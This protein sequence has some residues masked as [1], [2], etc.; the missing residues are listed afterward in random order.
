VRRADVAVI[1]GASG[2]SRST[3]TECFVREECKQNVPADG[4]RREQVERARIEMPG[5]LKKFGGVEVEEGRAKRTGTL[6]F[7]I[8]V[9]HDNKTI[10]FVRDVKE[11]VERGDSRSRFRKLWRRGP[12]ER[13]G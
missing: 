12:G 9:A 7:E 1:R 4:D 13:R 10:F 2:L 5:A 6:R 3:T 11:A 8:W